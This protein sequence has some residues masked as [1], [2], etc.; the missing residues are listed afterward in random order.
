MGYKTVKRKLNKKALLVI[1]L[2]LYLFIMSFYYVF[3]MPIK[4]IV[5]EGN[6]LVSD[7]DIISAANIDN[8]PSIFKISSKKI[9]KNIKKIN[10][11]EEVNVSKSFTG[12]I[13]INVKE[14]KI[15]FFNNLNDT[16]VLS[17]KKEI[18]DINP[19]NLICVPTLINYVPSDIYEG[20]IQKL[21]AINQDIIADISEIE[22]SPDI[23]DDV[24]INDSRFIL[25]MNDGN[26]VYIDI[27]NFDNLNKYKVIYSSLE[28]KGVLHLDVVYSDNN[29]ITFT[30]FAALA[31]QQKEKEGEND[32]LS[33]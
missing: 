12:T 33:Q 31:A 13:I 3:T 6:N 14:S 10:L 22:Y 2:T 21:S 9:I 23:K 28:E 27:V 26:Y 4:N 16:Y 20:L 11:I 32:E 30:S 8:Y 5:I 7:S 1:L 24:T 18:S 29:T 15:V 19:Q 25:R 17:N